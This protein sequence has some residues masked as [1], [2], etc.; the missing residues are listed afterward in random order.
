MCIFA[1]R[2]K[3]S[4]EYMNR[5]FL[6]LATLFFPSLLA[7][8]GVETDT[9]V[10]RLKGMRCE[11]CA[12]KVGTRLRQIEGVQKLHFDLE[13]RVVCVA[14][15]PQLTCADSIKAPLLGTRYKPSA[16]SP[17]DTI[18]RGLGFQMADMSCQRCADRITTRLKSMAGVDSLSPWLDKNYVFVRY[19]ANR[20]SKDSI[21]AVLKQLGFTPV[22]YYTSKT[23]G[24]AYFS[25][26]AEAANAETEELALTFDGVDDACVNPR[27]QAVAVTF[28]NTETSAETLLQAFREAGVEVT[29]PGD[30]VC[31]EN[32]K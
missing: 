3:T 14:Y 15:N 28:V 2:F 1:H 9:L 16:Y 29:V 8:A 12:H 5:L 4:E 13:R 18:M 23:I 21:R 32:K 11:E 31:E 22:N 30:H 24:Y 27:R 19:D 10:M 26:P 20:T 17:S 6:I 25:L 7:L